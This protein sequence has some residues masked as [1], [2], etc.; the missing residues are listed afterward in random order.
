VLFAG[1]LIMRGVFVG[2]SAGRLGCR[3]R[4]GYRRGRRSGLELRS[5]LA[6]V[7]MVSIGMFMLMTMIFM[8]VLVM[9]TIVRMI[10]RMI[11]IV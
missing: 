4:F 1:M 8:R 11:V 9:G 5:I 10:V 2:P 3:K 6:S 7:R